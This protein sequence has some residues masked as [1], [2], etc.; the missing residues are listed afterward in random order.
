MTYSILQG[1]NDKRQGYE[2]IENL[3][4][5][6]GYPINNEQE[7]FTFNELKLTVLKTGMYIEDNHYTD[8]DKAHRKKREVYLNKIKNDTLKI[9]A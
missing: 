6:Y 9:Y 7:I 1:I 5:K 2:I 8:I 3:I 4:I